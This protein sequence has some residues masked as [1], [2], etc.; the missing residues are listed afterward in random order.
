MQSSSC[1]VGRG[2]M[3]SFRW[4]ATSFLRRV[5][6]RPVATE[7]AWGKPDAS[8]CGQMHILLDCQPTPFPVGIPQI[9]LPLP[10][11]HRA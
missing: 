3:P 4:I 7:E 6:D 8:M 9:R 1:N 11:M 10:A 2:K 5:V